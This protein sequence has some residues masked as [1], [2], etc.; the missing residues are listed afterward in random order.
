LDQLAGKRLTLDLNGEQRKGVQEQLKGLADLKEL[1]EEEAKKRLDA[2]L[3]VLDKDRETLEAAGFRWPATGGF[4]QPPA[5]SPNPF[6]DEN[7]R[8]HLKSLQSQLS[9]SS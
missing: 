1:N 9:P 2:L 8:K 5:N 3:M 7:N 6:Q 4:F